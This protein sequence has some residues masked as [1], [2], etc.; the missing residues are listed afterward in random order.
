MA[1]H[2]KL[3]WQIVQVKIQLLIVMAIAVMDRYIYQGPD[4]PAMS[5][6]I[7]RPDVCTDKLGFAHLNMEPDVMKTNANLLVSLSCHD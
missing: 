5:D 7:H 1:L 3:L 2:W 4:H 6:A